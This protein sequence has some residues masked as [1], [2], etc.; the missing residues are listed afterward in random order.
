MNLIWI[1]IGEIWISIT[2]LTFALLYAITIIGIPFA[3]QHMKL[4]S[5]SL[6]PFGKEI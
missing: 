5:L 1:L 2:H 4:V 6:T 3:K